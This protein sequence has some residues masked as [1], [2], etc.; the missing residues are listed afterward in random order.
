MVSRDALLIDRATEKCNQDAF[1]DRTRPFLTPDTA[2]GTIKHLGVSRMKSR[3]FR[4]FRYVIT[5]LLLVA[6]AV[7]LLFACGLVPQEQVEKNYLLSMEEL[8]PEW[9][10]F[11]IIRQ[12]WG[13]YSLDSWTEV[14]ILSLSTYMDV[15][16][17]PDSVL[18]NSYPLEDDFTFSDAV[19]TVKNHEKADVFYPRYWHGF[20]TYVRALLSVMDYGTMRTLIMW[21]FF[22]L[23]GLCTLMLGFQTRSVWPPMLFVAAILFINPVIVSAL[24]QYSGCFIVAFIGILFVPMLLKK[25]ERAPML[26]M[27][28]GMTTQF[29]D[30]YTAPLVTFGLPMLSWLICL[31][32]SKPEMRAKEMLWL[33]LKSAATWFAAYFFMWIAKLAL[34]SIFTDQD[35]FGTAWEALATHI[36]V[37]KPAGT[38]ALYDK[39]GVLIAAFKHLFDW[40][41]LF[42]SAGVAVIAVIKM[43]VSRTDKHSYARALVMLFIAF[44]P[45]FWTLVATEPMYKC[46]HFQYRILAVTMLGGFYFWLMSVNRKK[47]P[48]MHP[49][50]QGDRLF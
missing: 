13:S 11:N 42:I 15:R 19:N 25:P 22:L 31:S 47:L 32:Y 26:F 30:F 9:Q 20:R 28:L 3:L 17:S 49:F 7:G 35:A 37:T 46:M 44:F 24:F 6:F 50:E 40:P 1:F 45:I 2:D 18:K 36:G 34:S 12:K 4:F 38:E 33:T 29:I 48:D 27:I 23:M 16:S 10:N 14:I 39:V 8:K 43:A 5:F 41:M 21:T